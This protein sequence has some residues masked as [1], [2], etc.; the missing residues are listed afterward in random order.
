MKGIAIIAAA[1]KGERAGVDKVWVKTNNKPILLRA[2]EPFFNVRAVEAVIV[3]VRAERAADARALF[4]DAPIPTVVITGGKDRTE[5]V[6]L[7]LK[8][9]CRLA[10][11]DKDCVVA[12]HDG[13]RPYVT[14]ELIERTMLLARS[15]GG[16]VPVVPITD[17]LRRLA[18]DGGSRALD[19]NGVVRVQTPQC[20]LLHR[21]LAAYETGESAPD[22][23][24]LYEKL[25][26][27]PALADGDPKN[28]KITYLSDIYDAATCRV[29]VGYD[30]HVLA[31]GRKLILGGVQIDHDKG[32]VGHSDADALTH[33][34]MDALLTA[35]GLPDIG[36]LFPP[37]DPKYKDADSIIL[38]KTVSRLL[39]DKG[40]APNNVSATVLA[41]KPKLAPYLAE[42]E[43]NISSALGIDRGSV[44]F[45][46]TTTEG[47]GII[48][49]EK[50]IAAHAVA[51]L[52]AT[53]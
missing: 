32:L 7:A 26:G 41:E 31:K 37:N 3:V 43:N 19:R 20:F 23:A 5:S 50:G 35:A 14:D 9:A 4:A 42:M 11:G 49:A 18:E 8:E 21:I 29:G 10:D 51:M 25:Y 36:H 45:A 48:G 39:Q 47:L 34:V 53:D 2:T 1:G 27:A 6:R 28:Q 46:A 33:A 22:D 17:A 24:T 30:A 44:K 16:A 38:L 40:F 13:A 15:L 52:R 12:I